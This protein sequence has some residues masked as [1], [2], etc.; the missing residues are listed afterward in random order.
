MLRMYGKCLQWPW[1]SHFQALMG[2]PLE[3]F[4]ELHW[5]AASPP[6][7]CGRARGAREGDGKGQLGRFCGGSILHHVDLTKALKPLL[8][9]FGAL[10]YIHPPALALGRPEDN[11]TGDLKL[12]TPKGAAFS[13][14]PWALGLCLQL[15]GS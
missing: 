4:A 8:T 14:V 12:S 13:Q 10:S 5:V 3:N 15:E 6:A 2:P 7:P 1:D 9:V 11:S